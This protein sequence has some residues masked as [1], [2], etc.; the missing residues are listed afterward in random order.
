MN[1]CLSLS[2]VIVI[3]SDLPTNI[4]PQA[5]SFRPGFTPG[6]PSGLLNTAFNISSIVSFVTTWS[7]TALLLRHYSKRAI[8]YWLIIGIPI[9]YFLGQFLYLFVNPFSILSLDALNFGILLMTLFLLSKPAGGV[10]F[11]FAFWNTTRKLE[12]G[13]VRDYMTIS[14]FGFILYFISNQAA[15]SFPV[16]SYPP[17][18]LATSLFVGLSSYYIMLGVYSSAVSISEDS[19]LRRSI[20]RLAI[21]EQNLLDGIGTAHMQQELEKRVLEI[22]KKLEKNMQEQTGI[23]SS[24]DEDD[25]KQ[26]L[27]QVIKEVQTYR[28]TDLE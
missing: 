15:T 19:Q 3:S 12:S 23:D 17:F 6:S 14:A 16:I 8:I 2:L 27:E 5:G 7:A 21:R 9:A 20:R 11:G 1:V 24:L 26:Y 25:I 18:G 10:L 4:G 13:P 22:A 28:K